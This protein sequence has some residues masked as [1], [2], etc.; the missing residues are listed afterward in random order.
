MTAGGSRAEV[1]EAFL[2]S[3]ERHRRAVDAYYRDFLHRPAD[4]GGESGWLTALAK[5]RLSAGAVAEAFLASEEYFARVASG[6]P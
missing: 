6:N 5:R 4:A 1:A 3:A 2:T